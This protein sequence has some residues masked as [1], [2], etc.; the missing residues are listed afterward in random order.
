MIVKLNQILVWNSL[1]GAKDYVV[2]ART[3]PP[4]VDENG[5]PIVPTPEDARVNLEVVNRDGGQVGIKI[6]KLFDDLGVEGDSY[7]LRVAARDENNDI[8]SIRELEV[9]L[10]DDTLPAPTGVSIV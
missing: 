1:R 4:L 5:D 2:E 9:I 10:G 3:N 6:K 7:V 8:G